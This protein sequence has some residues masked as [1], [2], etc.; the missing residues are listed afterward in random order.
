M[1]RPA[2]DE[3]PPTSH[4]RS[5]ADEDETP[6]GITDDTVDDG[7]KL[8]HDLEV[9]EANYAKGSDSEDEPGLLLHETFQ[10][11]AFD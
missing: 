11:V 4:K 7:Y 9:A 10:H 2:E 3:D 1:K 5:K 6:Q 8:W